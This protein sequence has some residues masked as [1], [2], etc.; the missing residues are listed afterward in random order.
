MHTFIPPVCNPKHDIKSKYS[1]EEC[2]AIFRL[3]S[4][5]RPGNDECA[6]DRTA[7]RTGDPIFVSSPRPPLS[8]G[9]FHAKY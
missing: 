1:A 3:T 4:D 7:T 6:S 2:S 5:A 9:A 8:S